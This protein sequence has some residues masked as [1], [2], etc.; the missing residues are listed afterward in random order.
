MILQTDVAVIGGGPAGLAAALSAYEAGARVIVLERDRELGGILQQCIHNGFGLHY[1][2]E[3]LTGPEYA[4][5]FIEKVNDT[6]IQVL[7]DTMALEFSADHTVLAVSVSHGLV[8]VKAKAIVLAMGCRERTRGALTIPGSRPAGVFTAGCAQRLVNMEGYMPGREIVIL[9]SGDIGLIMARR[10]TWEGAS[11]KLVCELMP[12]SSGLNRNI[13]QCLEDNGIPLRFN[14]TVV[15]IHGRERVSAVT[16]AEV[17]PT[18]RLPITG[19]EEEIACDTLLLSV[20]LIPENELSFQ[21]GVQMDERISGAIVD[22]NRQTNLPGVF[23]CGNVL[24]VHDLADN[25]SYE[26]EIAGRAAVSFALLQQGYVPGRWDQSAVDISNH[27][28]AKP[29]SDV[30]CN[31]SNLPPAPAKKITAAGF[32]RYVVPQMLSPKAVGKHDF[33]FRV[34]D[35]VKPACLT[36]TSGDTVLLRRKKQIMTPGEMEKVTLDVTG[37]DA[38]LQFFVEGGEG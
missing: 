8:T 33:Y 24:H 9:G 32:V 28:N 27:P 26:A 25:V 2:G 17:D 11:V 10:L 18:T 3:E 15:K 36:V 23:A 19:T 20:G 6:D 1:F 31:S 4:A 29:I 37:I 35:V 22:E 16:V 38:E 21:A 7:C 5:R 13:V 12:Y 30:C 34:G 14:H